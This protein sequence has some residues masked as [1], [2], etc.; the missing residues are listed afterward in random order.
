VKYQKKK[1]KFVDG[2]REKLI[3]YGPDALKSS[4]LLANILTTGCKRQDAM[5]LADRVMKEYGSKAITQERNVAQLIELLNIS[6]IKACQIIACFELGRRFFAKE[7]GNMPVIRMPEDVFKYL[8]EMKK[9]NK[10]EFRGL[11]LNTRNKL[12]HDEIISIGTLTANLVHPRE[13]FNPAIEYRAV[14]LIVAHNHP[15]GDPEP[16]KEDIRLTQRL[17]EASKI[18]GIDLLDHII[19]GNQGFRSLKE[20]GVIPISENLT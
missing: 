14:G 11:Y 18:I 6:C 13:V 10:E 16:S 4:E 20:M 8:E 15:S 17:V 2:P 7:P 12:I 9:L 1:E 5:T 19:I 3:K